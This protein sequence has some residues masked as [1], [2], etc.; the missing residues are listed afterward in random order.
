MAMSA[1][2]NSEMKMIRACL[3]LL[4]LAAFGT[5]ASATIV[6]DGYSIHAHPLAGVGRVAYPAY[7][8]YSASGYVMARSH[9]WR[10]YARDA[11]RGAPAL[12][13]VSQ[14]GAWSATSVREASVRNNLARA[15]AYRLGGRS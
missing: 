7:P 13:G 5:N 1:F 6:L 4:L 12:V 15:Q 11:Q 2:L 8:A 9:A 10:T 3:A 14:A